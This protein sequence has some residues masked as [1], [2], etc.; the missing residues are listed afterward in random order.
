VGF[1]VQRTKQVERLIEP[2]I[3]V[4]GGVMTTASQKHNGGPAPDSDRGRPAKQ[5]MDFKLTGIATKP[6]KKAVNFLLSNGIVCVANLE[7]Q[8]TWSS[9]HR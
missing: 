5:I 4:D 2:P 7:Q 6:T 8:V 9:R 1:F 3:L